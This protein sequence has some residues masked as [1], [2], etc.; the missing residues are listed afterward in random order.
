MGDF[1]KIKKV[2]GFYASDMHLSM[3]MLPYINKEI[4][5]NKKIIILSENN[6]KNN[7]IQILYKWKITDE[8]KEK[9]LNIN[10]E[11]SNIY[12]YENIEKII[13]N[14]I[15]KNQDINIFIVGKENYIKAGNENIIKYYEKNQKKLEYKKIKI[16]NCFEVNEFNK[17]IKEI[18]DMHDM[19]FNTSGEHE[20][21][22]IFNEYKRE[23]RKTI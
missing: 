1:C 8:E 15:E 7:I 4:K 5:E 21:E 20:I 22:E 9:I 11:I 16:I 3:M 17:N 10:W 2:C 19:I 23:N 13:K 12:K 6:L 18:L 14:N